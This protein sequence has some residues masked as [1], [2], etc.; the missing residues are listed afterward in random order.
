MKKTLKFPV[1]LQEMLSQPVVSL[2]QYRRLCKEYPFLAYLTGASLQHPQFFAVTVRPDDKGTR[3]FHWPKAS[4]EKDRHK[5]WMPILNMHEISQQSSCFSC[6]VRSLEWENER[7]FPLLGSFLSLEQKHYSAYIVEHWTFDLLTG[8]LVRVDA[9]PTIELREP[10]HA[11]TT[12]GSALKVLLPSAWHSELSVVIRTEG[13]QVGEK[14]GDA[15][16]AK[17]M[18]RF[19]IFASRNK[20]TSLVYTTRD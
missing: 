1:D 5:G 7:S 15:W 8:S 9:S 2:F 14:P 18:R 12:E 6:V 19:T 13:V 4:P 17:A 16:K 20:T 11:V 10:G 3:P